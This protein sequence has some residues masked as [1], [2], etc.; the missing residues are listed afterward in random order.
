MFTCATLPPPFAQ[1]LLRSLPA[2][3]L[4]TGRPLCLLNLALSAVGFALPTHVHLYLRGAIPLY[5]GG[6]MCQHRV[7]EWDLPPRSRPSLRHLC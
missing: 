2:D 4:S 3:A 6:P 5:V 7:A 1:T